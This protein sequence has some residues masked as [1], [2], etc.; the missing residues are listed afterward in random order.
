ME[1]G[2]VKFQAKTLTLIAESRR[3]PGKKH[4]HIYT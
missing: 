4:Y 3:R 2:G 1:G